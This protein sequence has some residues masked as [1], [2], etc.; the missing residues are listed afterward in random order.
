MS[1]GNETEDTHIPGWEKVDYLARACLRGLCVTNTQAAEIQQLYS[2][3]F[4][5]KKKSSLSA[6]QN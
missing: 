3:L 2:E 1:E 6:T 4:E 5:K